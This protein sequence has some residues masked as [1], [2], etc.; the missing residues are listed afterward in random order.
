[1]K[2]G[3]EERRATL[4]NI[5]EA[6]MAILTDKEIPEATELEMLFNLN[7]KDAP[8][9]SSMYVV[10]RIRHVTG[11][12]QEEGCRL[13]IEFIDIA[14]EDRRAIAEFIRTTLAMRSPQ[15]NKGVL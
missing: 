7:P 11:G 13:G 5:S 14:D 15:P 2:V 12:T 6:G 10:G 9:P 4:L 8:A 3:D 1:M